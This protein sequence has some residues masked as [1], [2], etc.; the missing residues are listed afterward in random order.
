[1]IDNSTKKQIVEHLNKYCSNA[2]SANKA[3]N[4]LGISNATISNMQSCKW[5]AI[6]E[7]MWRKMSKALGFKLDEQW[8][9]A[10]TVPFQVFTG[11]FDDA[12]L[13]A[14]VYGIVCQPGSGKTYTMDKYRKTNPNIWYV[15]CQR[16]TAETTFLHELLKSIGR[17]NSERRISVLLKMLE[18]LV[19]KNE[20]PLIIIDEI[21]KVKNDTLFL[22]IDLYNLLHNKCG[23]VLIGT[24]NLKQR[25]EKGL[26]HGHMCYNELYSRLG[27]RFI[28][29]PAPTDKDGAAVI[30][31]N[32]FTEQLEINTI[33]NDS[34][35]NDERSIDLRRV[36]RLVHKE[37]LLKG[38]EL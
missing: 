21:E 3:A 1:M 6:A 11:L 9:H 25:I 27:G 33:L 5:E 13:H 29:V 22:I 18:N 38:E 28:E 4:Q 15:K 16:H 10:D 12:R 7:D 8:R 17:N 30:R 35:V 36:E 2:G 14:N 19:D 34:H 32:G 31:A 23:L 24:P 26:T 20:S 37:K